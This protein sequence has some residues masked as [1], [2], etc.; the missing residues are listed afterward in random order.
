MKHCQKSFL[1]I[2]LI[3]SLILPLLPVRAA[4]SEGKLLTVTAQD[5]F[6]DRSLLTEILVKDGQCYI[7]PEE[8]A[9]LAGLGYETN[10]GTLFF[11]NPFTYSRIS[12]HPED[13]PHISWQ[14][15][16]YYSLEKMMDFLEVWIGVS[17]EGILYFSSLPYN[18]ITLGEQIR[19]VL[20]DAR[21]DADRLNNSLL[22]GALYT[23]G[24]IY[25]II[26]NMRVNAL[27][28][29]ARKEDYRSVLLKLVQS[30]DLEGEDI[31]GA[32]KKKNKV[33]GL[34]LDVMT[35]FLSKLDLDSETW[36][37]W[38]DYFNEIF[39]NSNGWTILSGL[40]NSDEFLQGINDGRKLDLA[41]LFF[42]NDIQELTKEAGKDYGL[43][44]PS[45]LSVF[46]LGDILELGSYYFSLFRSEGAFIEALETVT[47]DYPSQEFPVTPEEVWF[48]SQKAMIRTA[49]DPLIEDYHDFFRDE[50]Y[51][52]SLG[53]NIG[54]KIS[55]NIVS[56]TIKKLAFSSPE[57]LTLKIA[58]FLLDRFAKTKEKV[59]AIREMVLNI[60][61]QAFLKDYI[62][63]KLETLDSADAMGLIGAAELYLNAAK[64]SVKLFSYEALGQKYGVPTKTAEKTI[65]RELAEFLK[66]GDYQFRFT[67][68]NAAV[69]GTKLKDQRRLKHSFSAGAYQVD[70][71]YADSGSFLCDSLGNDYPISYSYC[72]PELSGS[73]DAAAKFNQTAR[74][75]FQ[76]YIQA[77]D[78]SIRYLTGEINATYTDMLTYADISEV[79]Y[80]TVLTDLE[81]EAGSQGSLLSI[82]LFRTYTNLWNEYED[83]QLYAFTLDTAN[84]K[85]LST[86]ELLSRVGLTSA[87]Y[88]ARLRPQLANLTDSPEAL[89]YTAKQAQKQIAEENRLYLDENGLLVSVFWIDNGS[90]HGCWEKIAVDPKAEA[91]SAEQYMKQGRQ[92]EEA[93]WQKAEESWKEQSVPSVEKMLLQQTFSPETLLSREDWFLKEILDEQWLLLKAFLPDTV[94]ADRVLLQS[95]LTAYQ[96]AVNAGGGAEAEGAVK[97]VQ[98]ALLLGCP[99]RAEMEYHYEDGD[100]GFFHADYSYDNMGRPTQ[101][102]IEKED[103]PGGLLVSYAYDA[104]DRETEFSIISS[105][106][107]QLYVRRKGYDAA[108]NITALTIGI[109]DDADMILSF[110]WD[111][112][113]EGRLMSARAGEGSESFFGD[114]TFTFLWNEA[115]LQEF[116]VTE[117]YNGEVMVE[118]IVFVRNAEKYLLTVQGDGYLGEEYMTTIPMLEASFDEHGT[119]DHFDCG[120]SLILSELDADETRIFF[121]YGENDTVSKIYTWSTYFEGSAEDYTDCAFDS[122]GRYLY[123]TYGYWQEEDVGY[124]EEDQRGLG[125]YY[126]F[127]SNGFRTEALYKINDVPTAIFSYSY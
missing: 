37:D 60:Q 52:L 55:E 103:E 106:G 69:D 117:E 88:W 59:T 127:D 62:E 46:D 9:V 25:D 73:G 95:A 91:V 3:L 107:E 64:N 121:T 47:A 102:I 104:R 120:R 56:G 20:D 19:S 24:N 49:A 84:G 7:R 74:D 86:E 54:E 115:E 53:K 118:R 44:L 51:W 45:S 87:D 39:A 96:D 70:T 76:P 79:N 21:Y 126:Q 109:P 78:G 83:P 12:T 98:S 32:L 48:A 100:I 2:L 4:E 68:P 26:T 58:G 77:Q 30:P 61:I 81:W 97:R 114:A 65:D 6:S 122:Y 99:T 14:R 111:Y 34:A 23:V 71:V 28:G 35:Q 82:G 75:F 16:T 72:L 90:A 85:A 29:G 22:T 41:D 5:L 42:R 119:I 110:V 89:E 50:S 10:G 93:A 124:F 113:T 94:P 38:A 101:I 15:T 66:Y 105:D 92:Y 108:G 80:G 112:D 40:R 116:A 11:K 17:Q 123:H 1:A 63:D 18:M 57:L 36:D 27:W 43:N 8:A 13:I 125:I 33:Y 31:S 67:A